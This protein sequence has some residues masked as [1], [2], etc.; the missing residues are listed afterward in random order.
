MADVT[1]PIATLSGSSHSVPDGQSCDRHPDRKAVARI[2]G[3]TDSFGSEMND[4]CQECLDEHRA[5]LKSPEAAERRKGICEW[6]KNPADDLRD[7]RDFE[8]GVSGRVYR[9]CGACV[10][11][12]NERLAEEADEFDRTRDDWDG[13][14]DD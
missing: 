13:D 1:G 6:C 2:Q 9:V 10:T 12:E 8:E 5:Y 14:Y 7:R 4:M 3:E 11:A